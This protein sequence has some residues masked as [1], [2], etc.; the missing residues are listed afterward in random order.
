MTSLELKDKIE[1][2]APGTLAEVTDTTCHQD[3]YHAVVTSPAFE[4]KI[5]LER[6]RMLYDLLKQEIDSGEI[7]AL[8]LK[9]DV[10]KH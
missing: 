10:P 3:H 5:T 2:L 6:H 9:T 7:H 4:G 8:T 1:A